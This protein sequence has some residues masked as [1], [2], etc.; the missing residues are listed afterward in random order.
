[1][2]APAETPP[3]YQATVVVFQAWLPRLQHMLQR[4]AGHLQSSGQDEVQLLQLRLAPDMLPLVVQ[5]EIAANFALRTCFPL[6]GLPVPPYGD[7]PPT[8]TGLQQRLDGALQQIAALPLPPFAHATRCVH[9]QAGRAPIELP[10]SDFVYLYAMPNFF[11]HVSISYALLRQWGLPL[12]K[13]D[14][15]GLH[16]Y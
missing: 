7:Y 11:F 5:V 14:F 9:D 6:A 16:R 15:D 12:S 13:G 3:L 10:A 8:L 4:A 2:H 1:M